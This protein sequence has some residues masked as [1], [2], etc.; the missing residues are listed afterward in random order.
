MCVC[1]NICDIIFVVYVLLVR[2]PTSGGL[3]ICDFVSTSFSDEDVPLLGESFAEALLSCIWKI[4]VLLLPMD[5]ARFGFAGMHVLMC[6]SDAVRFDFPIRC[7]GSRA[8]GETELC[9][10]VSMF[11]LV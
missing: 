6:R 9:G 10:A 7:S 5:C 2:H 4:C 8:V 1:V 11:Y 3:W